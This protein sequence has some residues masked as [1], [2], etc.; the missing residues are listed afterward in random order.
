[1]SSRSMLN[2]CKSV[3]LNITNTAFLTPKLLKPGP[4]SLPLQFQSLQHWS[5]L[6]KNTI[7]LLR[8]PEFLT[9]A[10]HMW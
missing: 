7:Y 4:F 9:T 2:Y 5:F 3:S 6:R 10:V 8:I 1:M